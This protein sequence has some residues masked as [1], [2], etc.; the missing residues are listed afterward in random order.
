MSE[1]I[2]VFAYNNKSIDYVKQAVFLAR[3]AKIYLNLPT[4]IITDNI[5]YANQWKEDFDHI[6]ELKSQAISTKSYNDGTIAKQTLVFK[7]DTRPHVYALTPY[8]KTLLLDTDFV[9]ANDI[10]SHCFKSSNNFMIYKDSYDIAN[11]RDYSEFKYVSDTGVEFCWAT[12]VYFTKC[13]TNKIFFDLVKHVQENWMHYRQVYRL[14]TPVY[15]NDHIFSIA[16]HIMN[17]FQK[18]DFAKKLPG[19]LFYVTDKD[20]LYSL[21]KNEF[22]ILL[23]KQNYLGQYTLAKLKNINLHV[24]NKFSL[25]DCIDV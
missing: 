13:S 8:E 16:I 3:R 10:L 11:F 18:G 14:E 5:N 20:I 1:G 12:C 25:M 6:I 2:V 19:K 24:M 21:N 15:R 17:N 7:N 22:T 9:I 23:E 4:S